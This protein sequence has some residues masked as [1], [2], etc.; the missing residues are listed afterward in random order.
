MDTSYAPPEQF[1][2]ALDQLH[3]TV[4]KESGSTD[5]GPDDYRERLEAITI[6]RLKAD[7]PIW[8]RT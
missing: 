3:D 6:D 2:T 7:V 8:K 5:F 1:R 4:A